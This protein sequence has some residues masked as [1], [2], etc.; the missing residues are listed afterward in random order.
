MRAEVHLDVVVMTSYNYFRVVLSE[1][2]KDYMLKSI[3][4]LGAVCGSSLCCF[5][6]FA[7][8]VC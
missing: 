8:L 3:C 6:R 5:S 7:V 2:G 4:A 1:G